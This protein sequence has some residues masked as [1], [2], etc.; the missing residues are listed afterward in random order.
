M[1]VYTHG[2]DILPRAGHT[3]NQDYENRGSVSPDPTICIVTTVLEYL[4]NTCLSSRSRGHS[5]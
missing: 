1:L 5:L 3:I 2:F 4:W